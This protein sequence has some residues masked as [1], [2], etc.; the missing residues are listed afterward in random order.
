MPPAS[1]TATTAAADGPDVAAKLRDYERGFRRAGLPLFSEDYSAAEDIFN[2]AAPLLGLVFL[3]EMLGAGNLDWPWWRNLLAIT[4]GL[5]ILLGAIALVNRARGRPAS[6]IPQRLGKTEL[7]GF[8]LIPALLPLIFSG[9]AGSAAITAGANLLMLGL[10]YAVVG[11]G[12]IP[13]VRWVLGRIVAQLRSALSLMAKAVPLLAIFALLSFPTQ[14]LWEIFS[15]PTAGIYATIIGLFVLLGIAFLTVR[16]PREAR[17][18]EREAGEGSP[19]LRR[20]QL[21]NV[22]LVM[23][24]SQATQVLLVSLMIGAFFTVFGVLAIDDEIRTQWLGSPGNTLASFDL[25]GE[26]L[27]LTSELLRVAGGLA[28]FTGF[29]FAIAMFTD[30]TYRQEFLDEITSEMRRSFQERAE[31]LRLRAGLVAL[32]R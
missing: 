24:V 13:I 26:Q 25:F 19:P 5:A 8:V 23:F 9:Q 29:Y 4:A 1:A 7:A 21:L 18:L 31:Y 27:E 17:R 10:I 6:A 20:R 16:L 30:S 11:L 2:R 14:E 12:L 28:A 3:G 22:G 32:G 15:Q